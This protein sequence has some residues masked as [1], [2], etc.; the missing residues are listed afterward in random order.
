[1]KSI[2]MEECWGELQQIKA[3]GIAVNYVFE[4]DGMKINY[5]FIMRK[6]CTIDG[7]EYYDIVTPRGQS[8][9]WIESSDKSGGRDLVREFEDAFDEYCRKNI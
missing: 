1:M 5:P 6:A 3:N 8:G 9:P 2:Y 7:F 4:K